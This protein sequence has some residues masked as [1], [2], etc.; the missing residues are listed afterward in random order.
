MNLGRYKEGGIPNFTSRGGSRTA[1]TI[2]H[3]EVAYHKS[4]IISLWSSSRPVKS[5]V[6]EEHLAGTAG[7]CHV[8]SGTET[9]RD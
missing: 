3:L 9:N 2:S 7:D 6:V 4:C 1:P 5:D 8:A